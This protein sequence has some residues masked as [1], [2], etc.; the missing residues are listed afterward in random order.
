VAREKL[1]LLDALPAGATG[2]VP[3]EHAAAARTRGR[4]VRTFGP[5]GESEVREAEGAPA[6]S[7]WLF[8][9]AEREFEWPGALRHQRILLAAALGVGA[10]LGVEPAAMLAAARSLP[11]PP[12]RGEIRRHGRVEF[13]LDCYNSSPAALAAAV[14]R[15]E[16]EPAQGR[17][18]CV[19]GT[20][21]ELGTEEA[22]WHRELG[23][24][25]AAS[26]IDRVFLVGRGAEWYREGLRE[27]GRDGEAVAG[28][29]GG[30]RRIAAALRPG[31]RILFKASR[32]EV[33]EK[34]AGRV[35]ALIG[36]DTPAA[37]ARGAA[38][39]GAR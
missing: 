22:S 12:L 14:E 23:R 38:R 9:G 18:L 15:L 19:L 16:V 10:T 7:V 20:M 29:E 31:D 1:S 6:R 21:E 32:R 8:D 26:R 35:A 39:E 30:A 5:G 28:D 13:L 17:R 3:V 27:G 2:W 37:A 25:I 33:L 36:D 34:I 4:A 24:R 11:E